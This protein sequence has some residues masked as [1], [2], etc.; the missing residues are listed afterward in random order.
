MY[1]GGYLIGQINKLTYRMINE[2]L[3]K[4]GVD[5]FNGAQGTI[6]YALWNNDGLTI[7]QISKI[8][9]LAKSSLTSTLNRMQKKGLIKISENPEDGR[10]KIIKLTDKTRKLEN[11]FNMVSDRMIENYYRD[12][13]NKEV[14][15]FER[16][17]ERV[18]K[19]LEKSK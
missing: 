11:D 6:L 13:S 5:A 7:K 18:L 19:N 9:G 12:F 10:S 3:K 14:M 15:E 17:L 4:R 16:Q 1:D 8:T 2:M